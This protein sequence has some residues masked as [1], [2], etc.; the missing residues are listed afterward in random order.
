MED[1]VVGE[2]DVVE[3]TADVMRGSWVGF[4]VVW[5]KTGM[6]VDVSKSGRDVGGAVE[7][8][9]EESAEVVGLVEST[10]GVLDV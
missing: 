9:N 6:V 3:S 5:V 7:I 2:A 1:C 10:A 8:E 4:V